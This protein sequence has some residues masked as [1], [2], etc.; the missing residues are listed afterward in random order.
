MVELNRFGWTV[1]DDDFSVWNLHIVP[2]TLFIYFL[3]TNF[4]SLFFKTWTIS[5]VKLYSWQ[6]SRHNERKI[7]NPLK[8]LNTIECYQVRGIQE[9]INWAPLMPRVYQ[10]YSCL[11][12]SCTSN[13]IVF[14]VW[15]QE[16]FKRFPLLCYF[17]LNVT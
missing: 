9:A 12:D 13:A 1:L 15:E 4:L 10:T 11:S 2:I 8:L 16:E 3:N 6:V 5:F 7:S 14:P 17:K